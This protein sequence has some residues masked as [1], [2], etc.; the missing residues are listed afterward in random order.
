MSQVLHLPKEIQ[1]FLVGQGFNAKSDV[2]WVGA[3]PELG[4]KVNDQQVA[5]RVTQGSR[6]SFVLID[7]E[8]KL[9]LY[10]AQENTKSLTS[11]D[12]SRWT[13]QVSSQV[14]D[15][16]LAQWASQV[17]QGLEGSSKS[18]PK[19]ITVAEARQASE[20][21]RGIREATGQAP[22]G[23]L[24]ATSLAEMTKLP[25]GNPAKDFLEGL[26]KN[27][28]SD[29]LNC[30][31]ERKTNPDTKCNTVYNK[32]Y[33]LALTMKS[34]KAFYSSGQVMAAKF[35]YLAKK[36]KV[37][38]L[39]PAGGGNVASLATAMALMENGAKSAE[40][41]FTELHDQN[42]EMALD[43]LKEWA[44]ANPNLEIPEPARW[45]EINPRHLD[46]SFVKK[47]RDDSKA[48]E[49]PR[50]LQ[51]QVKYLGKTITLTYALRDR[52]PEFP[53]LYFDPIDLDRSDVVI[54]HDAYSSIEDTQTSFLKQVLPRLDPKFQKVILIDNESLDNPKLEVYSQE[55]QKNAVVPGGVPVE[56]SYGHA[57][58][59]PVTG[60]KAIDFYWAMDELGQYSH[61]G[62]LILS[63]RDPLI[64]RAIESSGTR[65]LIDLFQFAGGYDK[66]T[67]RDVPTDIKGVEL[68]FVGSMFRS[69]GKTP[70]QYYTDKNN[71]GVKDDGEEISLESAVINWVSSQLGKF[72][73]AKD[74]EVLALL[75][76]RFLILTLDKKSYGYIERGKQGGFKEEANELFP[77]NLVSTMKRV[78]A[79]HKIPYPFDNPRDLDKADLKKIDAAIES[80][81]KK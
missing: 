65:E 41:I 27:F 69:G 33:P 44:K 64:K 71:N 81:R 23:S 13:R 42:A 70:S 62:A 76:A 15:V 6:S 5:F 39:Y 55:G 11:S 67:G 47:D 2:A 12:A 28:G 25:V 78:F 60:K 49:P 40:M 63:T 10:E 3:N 57:E 43:T 34:V 53:N 45:K 77:P 52:N 30:A 46:Q 22:T 50:R 26:L 37:T 32:Y 79:K 66:L 68:D 16:K 29:I 24:A 18:L 59:Y 31:K 61:P 58:H 75:T 9:H 73:S 56:G 19:T 36:G 80:Y 7:N 48:Q 21:A 51:L 20:A 72:Y 74:K 4:D 35:P 17:E 54:V 14:T 8:G 1:N 38:L